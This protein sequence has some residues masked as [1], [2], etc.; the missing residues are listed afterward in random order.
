[1]CSRRAGWVCCHSSSEGPPRCC[2]TGLSPHPQSNTWQRAGGDYTPVGA[3]PQI[4]YFT[5]KRSGVCLSCPNTQVEGQ[6]CVQAHTH[7][8]SGAH[9][10]T[11]TPRSTLFTHPKC[12]PPSH[13][14]RRCL[15]AHT[16]HTL[17]TYR[18]QQERRPTCLVCLLW[19]W[20]GALSWSPDHL[21]EEC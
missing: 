2:P 7:I 21:P 11:H 16:Q 13:L 6:V 15:H 3:D 5:W 1:M 9:M 18:T 8:H 14:L 12:A 19:R 20:P 4:L 17:G 10:H